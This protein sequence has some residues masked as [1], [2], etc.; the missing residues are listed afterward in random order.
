MRNKHSK[1]NK[2][3]IN[4]NKCTTLVGNDIT[5]N[6]AETFNMR[7]TLLNVCMQYSIVSYRQDV[8]Q[9]ISRNYSSCKTETLY[10]FNSISFLQSLAITILLSASMSLTMLG[11]SYKQNH[12]VFFLL[13]LV[14]F[15][16]HNVLKVHPGCCKW[17]NFLFFFFKAKQ[18]SIV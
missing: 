14:Y 5:T 16:E 8:A 3:D 1:M 7:S 2:T 6:V 4:F 18:Y 10:S 9:Q 13:S 12:A 11:V 17:Q 15:T